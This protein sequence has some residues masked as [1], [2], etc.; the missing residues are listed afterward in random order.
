MENGSF[1]R[2]AG[3]QAGAVWRGGGGLRGC[4]GGIGEW[5]GALGRVGGW[6]M[7]D[8]RMA[9]TARLG[10]GAATTYF[11]SGGFLYGMCTVP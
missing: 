9:S 7:A 8:G 3:R 1:G 10:F 4:G 2:Q 11:A 6:R 5:G